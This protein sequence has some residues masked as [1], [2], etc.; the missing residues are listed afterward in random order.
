MRLVVRMLA[1][2][3]RRA[4]VAVVEVRLRL[5]LGLQL[6]LRRLR[7]LERRQGLLLGHGLPVLLEHVRG[8]AGEHEGV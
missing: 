7:V 2:V 5:L 1:R 3:V 8:V 6:G 4:G